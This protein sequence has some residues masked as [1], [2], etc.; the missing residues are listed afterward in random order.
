MNMTVSAGVGNSAS[1]CSVNPSTGERE[2][3]DGSYERLPVQMPMDGLAQLDDVDPAVVQMIQSSELVRLDGDGIVPIGELLLRV[4]VHDDHRLGVVAFVEPADLGPQVRK[5]RMERSLLEGVEHRVEPEK[6]RRHD[7]CLKNHR[8]ELD[9]DEMIRIPREVV[10]IGGGDGQIL[11][12]AVFEVQRI[13]AKECL[14]G[15]AGR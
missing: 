15:G 9:R 10:P 6:I 1:I 3:S 8:V 11:I 5:G 14:D 12:L 2:R 7:S 4:L 13:L